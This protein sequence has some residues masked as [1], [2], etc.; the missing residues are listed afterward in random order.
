[1]Y[2]FFSELIKSSTQSII[3]I[4]NFVDETTLLMLSK[5][6]SECKVVIYTKKF[7]AE[8]QLDLAKHNQQYPT[9]EIKTLK[10]A[11]DRFLILD[12]NELYHIGASLKD[13]GKKWSAFSKLNEFLP[14]ILKKLQEM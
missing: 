13:F 14:E 5:R 11:R 2:V 10:T 7:T 9:N 1:V 3:L 6:N 12:Q 4:D 8:L